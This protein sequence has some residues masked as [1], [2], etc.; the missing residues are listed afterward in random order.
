MN[1]TRIKNLDYL[2]GVSA[3]LIMIYH[4]YS[5]I[6]GHA[7]TNCVISKFGTYGVAL[8][9]ILSGCTLFHVYSDKLQFEYNSLNEFFKKRFFR[10]F[11]LLWFAIGISLVLNKMN[12]GLDQIFIN[13]TGLFGVFA[14]DRSIAPGSWSIGNE[15]FFYLIFPVLVFLI[16]I[17]KFAWLLIYLT[18]LIIYIYFAFFK[19]QNINPKLRWAEYQNPLNQIF[20]FFTG[21]AIVIINRKYLLTKFTAI[22][23]FTISILVFF[24]FPVS[25]ELCNLYLGYNRIVF[26]FAL[27]III[28]IAY[29]RSVRLPKIVD[30]ILSL[31]GDISYSV[32]LLH[33]VVISIVSFAINFFNF[34]F[35]YLPICKFFFCLIIT[36]ILSYFIYNKFELFFIRF[37]N[38]RIK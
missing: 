15:L 26:T 31:G 30:K 6:F 10:I 11:P 17:K 37:S 25:G 12:Y 36:L 7:A 19:L 1:R 28:F 14:W 2:R 23:L 38:R 5:W 29:Q 20:L 13:I 34:N 4:Y 24:F 16:R 27:T 9:Y 22:S 21:I 33:P 35:Y 18:F 8:F 3:I 32:Y